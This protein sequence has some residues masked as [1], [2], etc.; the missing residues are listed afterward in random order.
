MLH[1][2]HWS[3]S[4][5]SEGAH[6]SMREPPYV[7]PSPKVWPSKFKFFKKQMGHPGLFFVYFRLFKQTLQFLQQICVK[8]CPSSIWCWDSNPQPSGHES[9]P[10][11]VYLSFIY[12]RASCDHGIVQ[13]HQ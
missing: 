1:K 10:A 3:L 13:L 12:R 8:K 5:N 6:P 7:G 4:T 11:L 2:H 9:P